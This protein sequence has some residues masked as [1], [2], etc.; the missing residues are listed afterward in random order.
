[1]EGDSFWHIFQKIWECKLEYYSYDR[2]DQNK[3]KDP[4]EHILYTQ[5][6]RG[7][8]KGMWEICP[9]MSYI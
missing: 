8:D 5:R 1:M 9:E 2:Y 3:I 6:V 7:Q 4:C